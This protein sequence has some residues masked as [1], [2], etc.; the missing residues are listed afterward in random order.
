M[1][2]VAVVILNWN[3]RK[4]IEQFLPIVIQHSGN[5]DIYLADNNSTD[6]SV[7]YVRRHFSSVKIILN[8]SNEGF[9]EGYNQALRNVKADYFILLNS[10]VEVTENWIDPVISLMEKDREIAACQPKILSLKERNK[11]E[12]AGAAGGFIDKWGYPFCRGRIFNSIEEDK[13][14]YDDNVEVFWA[15]GACL[16]I[17]SKTFFEAGELDKDFFAHM[18]EIDLCWRL[19]RLGYKIFYC[20]GSKVFHLGGGSLSAA[21]SKKTFLNFRNSLILL[22]KNLPAESLVKVFL[23]RLILDGIAGLRFLLQGKPT[24]TFAVIK[25]H[26]YIYFHYKK[27]MGKRKNIE[28]SFQKFS[29]IF[30]QSIIAAYFL[31]GKKTFKSLNFKYY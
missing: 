18:E 21:H 4:Y 22:L 17:K 23:I 20:G 12:Y 26:F 5:A 31:K 28:A 10:D 11:F 24:H 15:T 27:I 3:G 25:A 6:D 16:F 13:G 29:Q 19:K 14:Q 9:S 2:L 7:E 1:P 8:K 30:P